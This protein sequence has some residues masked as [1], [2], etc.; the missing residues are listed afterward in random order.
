MGGTEPIAIAYCG[1][2]VKEVL[3]GLPTDV[4]IYVSGNIIK[5]LI[6]LIIDK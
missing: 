6:K 2:I 1:S 4:K 3:A 5:K